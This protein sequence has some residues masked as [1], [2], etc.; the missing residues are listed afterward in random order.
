[1]STHRAGFALAAAGA[2]LAL[3]A[4]SLAAT[5]PW[6]TVPGVNPSAIANTLN[7]VSARTSADA[8]AVGSYTVGDDDRGR[9]M[10]AERWNGTAWTQV[11]T[12]DVPRFDERLLAVGASSATEA[13]AV[14][15]TNKIG[16]ASTNPLAA[17]WDG[18]AWTIVPTP[19]TSGSAK[20]I[21]DGVVSLGPTNAWAVGR[22]R[23]NAGNSALVEHWDGTAWSVVPTPNPTVPTGT[24]ASGAVLT[25]ISAVSPTDIWAVGSVALLAGTDVR[26]VTLTEHYDGRSWSVVPSPNA[27]VRNVLN[28]VVATGPNDVWAVGDTIDT[29]GTN[30]PDRTLVEHWNGVAWSIVRSPNALV[31]DAL[32]GVTAVSPTDMWAV[33][34]A[35][36][37]T[38]NVPLARTLTLHWDGAA[39]SVVASPNG[40]TGDTQLAATS[41]VPTTGEVWAVGTTGD[42]PADTFIVHR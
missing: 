34:T 16:F 41:A 6:T 5:A 10:L 40:P 39:W 19:A 23:V 15:S 37:R 12:P 18:T 29:T 20:S 25:G 31:E 26:G 27:T 33:G 9:N 24:T 3:A 2:V 14:G 36:D 7:G 4:P 42:A 1:M 28:G 38:G 35:V 17:H 21:L 13:W 22:S 8:W 32:A 30:L 11:P